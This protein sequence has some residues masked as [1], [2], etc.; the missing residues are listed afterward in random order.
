M[1]VSW[2]E[3]KE[4]AKLKG[5]SLQVKE[6]PGSYIIS[7]FDTYQEIICRLLKNPTDNTDLT[8]FLEN[9]YD[10]CNLKNSIPLTINQETFYKTVDES[11][12][13]RSPGIA[14][15]N[16]KHVTVSRF[17]ANGADPSAYVILV[18]D[19]GGDAEKIIASTK[20][21]IDIRLNTSIQELHITGD[22]VK[23]FQI[24]IINNDEITSPIIG[25]SYELV[26]VT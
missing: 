1:I 11:T 12:E 8:D 25:G 7:L 4:L 3:I 21:D 10:C 16:G 13:E 23:K 6:L 17:R 20:G 9:H 22:G 2:T 26:E 5:L 24:C 14:P 18:W 19:R 15:A